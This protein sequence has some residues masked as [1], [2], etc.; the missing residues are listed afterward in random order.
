[1]L[2]EHGGRSLRSIDRRLWD[3]PT[4]VPGTFVY[5][6]LKFTNHETMLTMCNKVLCDWKV[7]E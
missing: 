1:V 4:N 3:I 5:R 6:V 2:R 7:N